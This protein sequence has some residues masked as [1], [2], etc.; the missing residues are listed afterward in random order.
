MMPA[1]ERVRSAHVDPRWLPS[2]FLLVMGAALACFVQAFRLRRDVRRHVRW[3][4]AGAVIDVVG[5]ITVVVVA[6]G[7]ELHVPVRDAGVA[8]VHRVLAYVST[9]LLLVQV[10]SGVARARVHPALGHVFL[11]AYAATYVTAAV[12]YGPW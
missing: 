3:A 4:A 12:A 2:A 9:A 8:G 5:T 10:A 1:S 11:A 6:R 7:L